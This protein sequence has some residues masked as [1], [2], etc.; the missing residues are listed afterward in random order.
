MGR[1]G[2]IG[3]YTEVQS[4]LDAVLE[5]IATSS[6]VKGEQLKVGLVRSE[7]A[8]RLGSNESGWHDTALGSAWQ[9]C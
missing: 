6:A 7:Q 9:S 2:T 1:L 3:S 4:S 8:R 5:N